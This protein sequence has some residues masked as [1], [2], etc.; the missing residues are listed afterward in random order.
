M[1]N[2]VDVQTETSPEA[3]RD[4]LVRQAYSPVRW[5]ESVEAMRA[6]GIST[7]YEFGPGK[8]LAGLV[9]RIDGEM[10]VEA[11]TDAEALARLAQ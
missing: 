4:A 11:V 1:L 8:V 2:N 6:C 9:K 7:V 5:I 3:I 10:T